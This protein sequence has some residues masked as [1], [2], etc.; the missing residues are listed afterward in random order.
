M[1]FRCEYLVFC[2]NYLDFFLRA[3]S[4]EVHYNEIRDQPTLIKLEKESKETVRA[5]SLYFFHKVTIWLL[6][7]NYCLTCFA[8]YSAA[9]ESKHFLWVFFYGFV[10]IV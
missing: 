2:Y 8:S 4:T 9:Y 7:N 10:A 6:W 1:G 3:S 5:R